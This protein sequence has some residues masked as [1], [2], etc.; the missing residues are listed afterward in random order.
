[1]AEIGGFN[2]ATGPWPPEE[3]GRVDKAKYHHLGGEGVMY[4]RVGEGRPILCGSR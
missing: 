1:M 2:T 4:L 3:M